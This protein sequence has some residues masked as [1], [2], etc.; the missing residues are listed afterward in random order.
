MAAPLWSRAQG[1]KP[2]PM[3]IGD[4][5]GLPVATASSRPEKG[6]ASAKA[7]R[8]ELANYRGPHKG[9]DQLA[10][11]GCHPIH[12]PRPARTRPHS[13]FLKWLGKNEG[14]NWQ[15]ETAGFHEERRARKVARAIGVTTGQKE[16]SV[17][18]PKPPTQTAQAIPPA[19]LKLGGLPCSLVSHCSRH[20]IR[21]KALARITP[22]KPGVPS[23]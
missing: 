8:A 10:T 18:R 19:L 13:R 16:T 4:A 2:A 22:D 14:A 1:A 12:P 6:A 17:S 20:P 23:G 21:I 9:A 11:T 15:E 7:R 5:A 3:T